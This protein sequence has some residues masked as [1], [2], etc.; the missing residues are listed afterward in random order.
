VDQFFRGDGGIYGRFNWVALGCYLAGIAI[1]VP[2]VNTTMFEGP[3]AKTFSGVDISWII[4]L[5]VISPL[6]YLIATRLRPAPASRAAKTRPTA[7]TTSRA[8]SRFPPHA[9]AGR[10]WRASVQ[11]F[12]P[13]YA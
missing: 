2:F 3:V 4:C 6:Y 9:S 7:A 1:E 13:S 8:A 10:C 12:T 11:T 5:M